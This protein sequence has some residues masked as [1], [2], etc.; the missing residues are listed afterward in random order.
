MPS[1]IAIV[2]A[3][4]ELADRY[5]QGR[6]PYSFRGYVAV[7]SGEPLGF[8]GVFRAYGRLW[9]FSGFSPELRPH[10]KVRVA[11]VRKLVSLLDGLPCPVYATADPAEETAPAL[12]ARLGFVPTGEFLDGAE[13]LM[14]RPYGLDASNRSGD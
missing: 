9:V 11:G 12:L 1:D 2:P 10:R 14:R 13:I 5:W 3:T 7:R 6:P 4:Q 8:A